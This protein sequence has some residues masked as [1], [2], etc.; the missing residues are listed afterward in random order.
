MFFLLCFLCSINL[1]CGEVCRWVLSV[2]YLKIW[3][4]HLVSAD[5]IDSTPLNMWTLINKHSYG[6]MSRE[7][8]GGGDT[9][10]KAQC[11]CCQLQ[12]QLQTLVWCLRKIANKVLFAQLFADNKYVMLTH[13]CISQNEQSMHSYYNRVL[14][15]YS[16]LQSSNQVI[17]YIYLSHA[18][19]H[20]PDSRFISTLQ[21]H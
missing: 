4:V 20:F 7:N 14:C 2:L 3:T 5:T 21:T 11:Y 12:G 15:L 17:D 18:T 10:R 8:E 1:L 6:N 9:K 16:R 19:H 13:T